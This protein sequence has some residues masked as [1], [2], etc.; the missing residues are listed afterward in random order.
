MQYQTRRSYI[1]ISVVNA[2]LN[3]DL[4][5]VDVRE[6]LLVLIVSNLADVV[7]PWN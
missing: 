6:G 2:K 1:H 7:P 4:I 3:V 5:I